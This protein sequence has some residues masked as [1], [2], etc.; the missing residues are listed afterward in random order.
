MDEKF[1]MPDYQGLLSAA[2]LY[3]V[4]QAFKATRALTSVTSQTQFQC[5]LTAPLHVFNTVLYLGQHKATPD[6]EW[7]ERNKEVH[8]AVQSK[9]ICGEKVTWPRQVALTASRKHLLPD[10]DWLQYARGNIAITA[11]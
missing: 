5:Q 2:K 10:D 9:W 8:D 7:Q 11:L 6:I 4:S 1:P 3:T